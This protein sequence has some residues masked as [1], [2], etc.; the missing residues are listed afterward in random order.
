MK[1]NHIHLAAGL[2]KDVTSGMRYDCNLIIEID[3]EKAM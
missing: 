1:R 3:L 2:N